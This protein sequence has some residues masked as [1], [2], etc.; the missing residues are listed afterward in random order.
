MVLEVIFYLILGI[1]IIKIAKLI[2]LVGEKVKVVKLVI[3]RAILIVILNTHDLKY[4]FYN[5]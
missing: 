3:I 5:M 1:V 4:N 2:Y